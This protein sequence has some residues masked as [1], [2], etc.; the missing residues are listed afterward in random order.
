MTLKIAQLLIKNGARIKESDNIL[1]RVCSLY[2]DH[3]PLVELLVKNGANVSVES[4][5]LMAAKFKNWEICPPHQLGDTLIH[6]CSSESN[7]DLI[8]YLVE[9]RGVNVNYTLMFPNLKLLN[10]VK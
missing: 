7:L 4:P 10:M 8:K 5:L 9:E 3:L 1:S 6:L 2:F